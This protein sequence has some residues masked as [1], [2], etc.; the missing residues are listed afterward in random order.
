MA[1]HGLGPVGRESYRKL[2]DRL[3]ALRSREGWSVASCA[4]QAGV[5]RRTWEYF[6]AGERVPAAATM[7]AMFRVFGHQLWIRVGRAE[8]S[9]QER[10]ER[11][12]SP[13]LASSR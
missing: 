7:S 13:I 11:P 5:S 10:P 12:T 8:D 9:V 3:R 1:K 4:A 6:E 2:G